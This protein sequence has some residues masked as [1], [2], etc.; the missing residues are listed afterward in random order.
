[1]N[2]RFLSTGTET[3]P[4]TGTPRKEEV[5]AA[6]LQMG[7]ER[8]H[9]TVL[10]TLGI[11]LAFY[12]VLQPLLP[13]PQGLYWLAILVGVATLRYLLW[14][15]YTAAQRRGVS[16]ISPLW[17]SIYILA[18]ILAGASWSVGPLLLFEAGASHEMMLILA[19]SILAVGAVAASSLSAQFMA[20]QGFLLA[21]FGPLVWIFLRAETESSW[22][23][24]GVISAGLLLLLISGRESG[25]ATRIL[26]H[27]RLKLSQ[28]METAHC[29]LK[30]SEQ[31]RQKIRELNEKLEQRVTERTQAL[32]D[33]DAQLREAL[34]LNQEIFTASAAGIAV[35]RQ[36]GPC[37]MGNPAYG[38]IVGASEEIVL[39][40]NFLKKPAWRKT[41]GRKLALKVLETGVGESLHTQTTTT[42]GLNVWLFCQFTRI[43][44]HDQP[45]LLVMI[46]DTTLHK[47]AEEEIRKLAF[48]DHL[49]GLPN[50]RLLTDRL[51]HA[52][53]SARRHGTQCALL[54]LDLD[55]FKVLNDTMG[56]EVGD[57]FLLEIADRLRGCLRADDTLARQGGDEFMI[58]LEGLD[59]GP[60]AA[61][62]VESLAVKI[63]QVISQPYS[64]DIPVQTTSPNPR[65]SSYHCTSSIG[66]ALFQDE[67]I[68]ADE[69]LKRAD[70]AMYQAK[71][72]G[73]NTLRFFDPEM[74][75]R[76]SAQATLE[77]DLRESVRRNEFLLHYQAQADEEGHIVGA[78]ALVRW[79][80]PVRGLV[81]PAE[82][83]PIAESTGLILPI[84]QWVLETACQ[85]LQ[86]WSGQAV[87][88][89]LTLAVNVSARQFLR[90][91]YVSQVEA[92]LDRYQ[93][94]PGRLK[95]EL[96]ES[97]LAHDVD[98]IIA[99]MTALQL[100]GVSFSLDDFGTGYSSLS[101]L[102][103]LPLSQLKIDQSF[104]RDVLVD[105]ND[106]SIARTIVALGKSM[107]LDVIA[108]GVETREQRAFLAA[109]GC[110]LYQ[111]YLFG[112][113]ASADEFENMLS[114]SPGSTEGGHP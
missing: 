66:I 1:M 11:C 53:L 45:H 40:D 42:N 104:V 46:Q 114:V 107:G 18:A 26:I 9:L 55:N 29:S 112:K 109:N 72:S 10:M 108:E 13:M 113:P 64:L 41:G 91:D 20:M 86:S 23:T 92:V 17:K 102:K 54:L 100:R 48:H 28:A 85:Q 22:V 21:A 62:Q 30:S 105:P 83:I 8:M 88:E 89:N 111:G 31:S 38:R 3:P 90:P 75:A 5:E 63:Q 65:S 73:R 43:M 36:D 34:S 97:L 87:F 82:F 110:H 76:V 68:S 57:R 69:L 24:A 71:S 98:D 60:M 27:T 33:K 6:L 7:Y 2:L 94:P 59:S 103:R 77:S 84:G 80:H 93:I 51:Q 99:K 16:L 106:A 35:Y 25:K 39:A 14:F 15:A 61:S 81:S 19:L 56:H 78:E 52:G 50:R 49:T 37:I 12:F 79:Q 58:I 96:T 67:S 44:H 95:L 32:L 74:Q 4:L 101:Y 70:T 47:L